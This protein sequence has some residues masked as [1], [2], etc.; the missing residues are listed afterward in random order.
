MDELSE[1]DSCVNILSAF[2]Y[3]SS[4]I[5]FVRRVIFQTLDYFVEAEESSI[6]YSLL[7]RV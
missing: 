5:E 2:F 3:L 7:A 1:L 4:E 6:D